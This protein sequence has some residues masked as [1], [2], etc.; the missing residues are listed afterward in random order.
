MLGPSAEKNVG[1][2]TVAVYDDD[3]TIAEVQRQQAISGGNPIEVESD[4]SDDDDDD[5]DDDQPK[6]SA[7]EL[8]EFCEQVEA[9]YVARLHADSSLDLLHN[10]R[11]FRGVLRREVRQKAT[12]TTLD[13]FWNMQ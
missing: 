9:A 4:D 2:A 1:E 6:P 13:S 7:T 3:A 11:A 8:I 10:L 5:D 12:Q